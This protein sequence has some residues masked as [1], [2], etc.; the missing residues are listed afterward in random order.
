MWFGPDKVNK[1]RGK[2]FKGKQR[3]KEGELVG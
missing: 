1:T 2:A 3:E